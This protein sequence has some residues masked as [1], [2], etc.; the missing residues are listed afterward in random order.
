VCCLP[1][2]FKGNSIIIKVESD[3]QEEFFMYAQN[4]KNRRKL[5]WAGLIF[6]IF[7]ISLLSS[8][9]CKDV[10]NY[11]PETVKESIRKRIENGDSVGIVVGVIDADGT[12]VY[13]SHGSKTMNE[14][15]PVDKNS[16]YE[17]GSISKVFTSTIL[18]DMVLKNEVTDRK[19]SA[20]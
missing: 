2:F 12:R 8:S 18:A 10:S 15:D 13:F 3:I 19:I 9:A 20:L 14:Y 17:I 16:V 11:I 7:S 6:F 5:V 1:F 4:K